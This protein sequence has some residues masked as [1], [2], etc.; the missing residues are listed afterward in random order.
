VRNDPVLRRIG[1]LAGRYRRMAQSRQRR[2]VRHGL[3]DVVG[4]TLDGDLARV[5]PHELAKLVVPEFEL[6]TF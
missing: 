6:D 3:D 2:K 4:V 1:E 5:L